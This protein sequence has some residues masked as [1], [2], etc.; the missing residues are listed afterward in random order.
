[1]E[2][3]ICLSIAEKTLD[4]LSRSLIEAHKY[5]PDLI[6][7]RIDYLVEINVS[8]LKS[9][10]SPHLNSSVLTLRSRGEGGY[11]EGS[12]EKRE[13]VISKLIEAKPFFVDIELS[14]LKRNNQLREKCLEEG[15]KTIV[16]WHNFERTPGKVELKEKLEEAKNLGE[17]VKIVT[18]ALKIEDNIVALELYKLRK[19]NLI[20][21]CMGE[22]GVISRVLCLL[23]GAPFTYACLP[24]KKVA[25]GQL[26][27][28]TLKRLLDSIEK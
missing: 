5:K 19:K 21:F 4:E 6:E 17:I 14:T 16:S 3:S 22:I 7:I 25:T 11:F 2:T 15:V 8:K 23:A 12:E 1:M 20:A 18:K 26:D 28:V 10:L 9:M 24:S 27:I 13:E